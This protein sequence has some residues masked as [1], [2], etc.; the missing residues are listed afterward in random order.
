MLC[1]YELRYPVSL[2]QQ[3]FAG[4]RQDRQQLLEGHEGFFEVKGQL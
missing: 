4:C 1:V 2:R 3:L